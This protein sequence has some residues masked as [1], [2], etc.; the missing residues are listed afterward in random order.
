MR[1]LVARVA[2]G[3]GF[4]PVQQRVGLDQVVDVGRCTL[5]RVHQAGLGIGADVRLHPEV[6]LIAHP[7]LVYLGVARTRAA[8]RGIRGGDPPASLEQQPLRDQQRMDGGQHL[9]GQ[10]VTLQQVTEPKSD[11]LVRQPG[12]SV[13]ARQPTPANSRHTYTSCS[14][15]SI[16][17]SLSVNHCC[18]K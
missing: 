18:R 2:E 7:C 8:L 6:P 3:V 15:S 10:L 14:A 9:L 1:T 4:V 11:A 17:G 13:Q 16:A 12:I 5:D